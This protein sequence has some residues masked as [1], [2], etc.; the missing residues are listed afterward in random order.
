MAVS[1]ELVAKFKADTADFNRKVEQVNQSIKKTSY[2]V[3]EL[4]D[5][6]T[7]LEQKNQRL[8][9]S[10]ARLEASTQRTANAMLK[11]SIESQLLS[12]NV[13]RLNQSVNSQSSAMA[14]VAIGAGAMAGG[15][16]GVASAVGLAAVAVGA[17]SVKVGSDMESATKRIE[18]M[19]GSAEKTTYVMAQLR[20]SGYES[21]KSILALTESYSKLTP[22]VE[23]G[24]VTLQESIDL[25]KGL[26]TTATALGASNEQL[27]TVMY[28]L[29]QALGSGVV[30]AEEF[31]QVTEPL[32][33]IINRMEQATGLASGELRKMINEGLITSDMFKS[34]LIP[35]LNSFEKEAENMS[36][37]LKVQAGKMSNTFIALG[38]DIYDGLN[39]PMASFIGLID[40]AAQNLVSLERKSKSGLESRLK[41]LEV[42]R[43]MQTTGFMSAFTSDEEKRENFKSAFNEEAK[44]QSMLR[45]DKPTFKKNDTQKTEIKIDSDLQNEIKRLREQLNK[46]GG[47]RVGGGRARQVRHSRP[48]DNVSSV[49]SKVANSEAIKEDDLFPVEVKSYAQQV[50]E[51]LGQFSIDA[52]EETSIIK[53]VFG[54]MQES[55]VAGFVTM[56]TNG[57]NSFK[58][59][60]KSIIDDI[61]SIIVRTLA[62]QAITGIV[63]S[64]VGALSS[65]GTGAGSSSSTPKNTSSGV[66]FGSHGSKGFVSG[67]RANGGSVNANSAYVVGERG[68]EIL[69]MGSQSGYVHSNEKSFGGGNNSM[70]VNIDARGASNGV[71]RDIRRVMNEVNNLRKQV[72][73]IAKSAVRN[74]NSRNAGFL[75]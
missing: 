21:G 14:S 28:G 74:E 58:E 27:S 38:E 22:F 65:A 55:I 2:S 36:D 24:S 25:Q 54:D 1:Q 37:T 29:S 15:L 6:N 69:Q 64:A 40:D 51:S 61:Q 8:I 41:Q 73:S 75:A 3:D 56:S 43:K 71:E 31:N 19:V 53:D 39:K 70:V 11:A 13:S 68:P 23:N 59:M 42:I 49:K 44:I 60:A 67:A 72:P 10:Q 32:P 63:N 33:G 9:N 66:G 16:V 57:K 26:T 62:M 5:K 52:K 12:N 18:A 4:A 30:R 50:S 35:A 7:K 46:G 45:G 47:S 20:D 17:F 34:I 48:I